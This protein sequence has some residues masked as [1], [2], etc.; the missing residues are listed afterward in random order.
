MSLNGIADAKNA[1]SR[2][3]K[4]LLAEVDDVEIR[5]RRESRGAA[6]HADTRP[7]E[8]GLETDLVQDEKLD[9]AIRVDNAS[10]TWS[11]GRSQPSRSEKLTSSS[12]AFTLRNI[13][14]EIPHGQLIAIV[15]GVG[16]GKSSL[17]QGLIGGAEKLSC[18]A[19]SF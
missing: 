19:A 7:E 9:V 16:S 8:K 3:R 4:V 15:G 10:F 1:V 12:E 17:L 13:S 2:V 14:F 5:A 11:H 18:V 6:R